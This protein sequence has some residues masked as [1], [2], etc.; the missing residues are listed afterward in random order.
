MKLRCFYTI[1]FAQFV[2]GCSENPVSR[3]AA[4]DVLDVTDVRGDP[5]ND[6]GTDVVLPP[7]QRLIVLTDRARDSRIETREQMIATIEMQ[8]SGEPLAEFLGRDLAGYDRTMLPVNLYSDPAVSPTV[9]QRDLLGFASAVESYEYSKLAMNMLAF[10]STAGT[11]LAHARYANPSGATD[12][13]AMMLLRDRVQRYAIASHAGVRG[14]MG[15]EQVGF[16]TVPAPMDN[17]LNVLGFGGF[18]PAVHPFPR[19]DPTMAPSRGSTRGCSLAGGYGASAGMQQIVGDYECGYSSLHLATSRS[20]SLAVVRAISPGTSG[21]AAW[22]YALWVINYLQI[23]HDSTGAALTQIAEEDLARVGVEGNMVRGVLPDGGPST[24]GTWLGSTDLEGFQAAFLID[25]LAAQAHDWITSL[26]TTDATNLS[27]F[28]S[29]RDALAYDYESPLRWFPAEITYSETVDEQYGYHRPE[30]LRITRNESLLIDLLGVLGGNAETF[31]LTDRRNNDVGASASTRAYFDGNP[32]ASDNLEP[33]GEA[34]LH[35]QT[36]AAMKLALV[37]LDRVHRDPTTGAL[38]DTATVVDTRLTR[39]TTV[40]TFST[41]YAVV[42][43]RAV[44]RSLAGRLTLYA[45]ATPD[46]AVTRTALDGT[47]MRGAPNGDSVANR[48]NTLLRA[49]GEM[50]F[51]RLTTD[52]GRAYNRYDLERN[53]PES[54]DGDLDAYTA[55]LRGLI[56]VSLATGETRYLARAEQVYTR[57]ERLFYRPALR[58][59]VTRPGDTEVV[60][61]PLRFGMLQASLREILKLI[62]SAPGRENF[63]RTVQSH[64]ARLNKLVLNGWDDF[65]DDERIDW[66]EEC[67]F[68][69]GEQVRGGLQMGERALTGELGVVDGTIVEDRDRDCVPEISA[70]RLP[71]SLAT[72]IRFTPRAP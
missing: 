57:M 25:I 60:F 54:V 22:K 12:T 19:F 1:F 3:D 62:A 43:L 33:D 35:D 64:I 23:M 4:I 50:L 16:V 49:Q 32:F 10:E 46:T 30:R 41:A 71:A 7:R 2:F 26:S 34:T 37:T 5:P 72:S 51:T 31:A 58:A 59:W 14:V 52:E 65:N 24:R 69:V 67:S 18:W 40:S 28:A 47:S 70:V 27:G 39:G 55:A 48:L 21:W 15:G 6:L 29:I 13:A 56:E 42:T 66:P 11:S 68:R 20:D 38:V 17:P 61:T 63:S 44:R 53:Q 9:E 36:L 8:Q 45:N